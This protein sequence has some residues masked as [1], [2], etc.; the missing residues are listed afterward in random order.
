MSKAIPLD[1]SDAERSVGCMR[2]AF[3]KRFMG[4]LEATSM[5]VMLGV[6][7]KDIGSGGYVALERIE[8]V[9]DGRKGSFCLQHSSLMSQGKPDQT[10]RVVPDSGTHELAGLSG[11]MVIDVVNGEHFFS[12]DYSL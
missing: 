7:N 5:V 9:L 12:F 8:G 1:V 6:M 11:N 10:I 3:E 2:M 4:Q